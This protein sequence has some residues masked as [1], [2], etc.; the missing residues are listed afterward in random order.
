[1]FDLLSLHAEHMRSHPQDREVVWIRLK[2]SPP[3]YFVAVPRAWHY[4]CVFFADLRLILHS[5]EQP[6][7]LFAVAG[8]CWVILSNRL[9]KK[10]LLL[11]FFLYVG[12]GIY[13]MGMQNINKNIKPIAFKLRIKITCSASNTTVLFP[14]TL[15]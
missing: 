12:E 15:S 10:M 9:L 14:L 2:S 3:C 11:I 13:H 7:C 5:L 6:M 4:H 8:H 1:M